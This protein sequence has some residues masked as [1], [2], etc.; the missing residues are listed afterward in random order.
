MRGRSDHLHNIQIYNKIKKYNSFQNLRKNY[1]I[2]LL[3][4]GSNDQKNNSA[5][6]LNISLFYSCLCRGD[7]GSSSYLRSIISR[8]VMMNS[9]PIIHHKHRSVSDINLNFQ[10]LPIP[11][12]Y[13]CVPM[14]RTFQGSYGLCAMFGIDKVILASE[15][16]NPRPVK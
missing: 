13:P 5:L 1:F 10:P 7:G 8:D 9:L 16:K 3:S 11:F 15:C 6:T 14:F 4:I 12:F 2:L